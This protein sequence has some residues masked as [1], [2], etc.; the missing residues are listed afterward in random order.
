MTSLNKPVILASSS[1]YRKNLLGKIL[2]DFS[3][4]AP[5]INEAPLPNETVE[6]MVQRLSLAKAQKL[7]E[8]HPDHIIIASDQSAALDNKPL[9]KAGCFEKAVH[10]LR[11]Q[12]GKT[13][14][15]FTGLAVYNPA[16]GQFY[17]DMDQ[18]FVTFRQLSD[19]QIENYLK[20]EQPYDCAGSFKSE[21]LG[22]ILFEKIQTDDPNALIGLPLI[23]L[24]SILD[25]IGLKL[26]QTSPS[27]QA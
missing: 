15:F 1:P 13:L 8:S 6:Q 12:Q 26:P 18:T 22:I 10:Q 4:L 5:N 19:D 14:T 11:H 23:K 24:V 16:N 2:A 25:K 7:A 21:G 20:I 9:G 17:Q 27:N 3:C